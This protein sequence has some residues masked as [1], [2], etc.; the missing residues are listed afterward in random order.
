MFSFGADYFQVDGQTN[1]FCPFLLLFSNGSIV[2][3]TSLCCSFILCV[4]TI[5]RCG[6]KVDRV[7][8]SSPLLDH[9]FQGGA[10][11]WVCLSAV[12]C[13]CLVNSHKKTAFVLC[14]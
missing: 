5:P 10:N 3:T 9:Y 11:P 14:C 7:C 6:P 8:A 4:Q 12:Q 2:K 13:F 1:S